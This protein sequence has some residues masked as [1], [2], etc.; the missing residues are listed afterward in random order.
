MA[1]VP[2]KNVSPIVALLANFFCFWV[3]GYVLIGQNKKA[4]MVF[5]AVVIGSF[6]CS[7]PG[8]VVGILGLM[9]VMATAEAIAR[10]ESV[11]ENEYRNPTLHKIVSI[12]D[13][14]A[15]LKA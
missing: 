12:L 7:I 6:L 5:V 14:S 1:A 10:G 4:L 15:T 13:K 2:N 8:L 3:L 9:D 11:D